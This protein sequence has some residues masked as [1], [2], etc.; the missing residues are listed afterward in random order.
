MAQKATVTDVLTQGYV[1]VTLW[2]DDD[3]PGKTRE[4]AETDEKK[5]VKRG[6]IVELRPIQPRNEPIAR[7]AYIA[8]VIFFLFGMLLSKNF[9]WPERILNSAIL[10]FLTF[11][12][13][14]LM[15]RRARLR[16]R[17]TWRV[18]KTLQKAE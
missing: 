18:V 1:E 6:D 14:W 10:G 7:I 2:G 13:A 15:N 5:K 8:P 4:I 16:R 11:I 9:S 12:L 3:Q 17:M